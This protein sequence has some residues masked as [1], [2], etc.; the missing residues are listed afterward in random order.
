MKHI[1]FFQ[2]KTYNLLSINAIWRSF[3]FI[4]IMSVTQINFAQNCSVN[5]GGNR[6]VCANSVTLTGTRSTNFSGNPTWSLLSFTPSPGGSSSTAGVTIVSPNSL[7]TNVTGLNTSGVYI[8]RLTQACTA[9]GNAISD[10]EIT[11]F[12]NTGFT[13]GPDVSATVCATTGTTNLT[14]AVIPAG[15]TGSWAIENT[16]KR[17]RYNDATNINGQLSSTTIANPTFSLINKTNHTEDPTYTLTLTITSLDG[18]CSYTDSRVV[19]FCPNTNLTIP[20]TTTTSCTDLTGQEFVN[21]S[22]GPIWATSLSF[23]GPVFTSS[24]TLSLNVISQPPGANMQLVRMQ[25]SQGSTAS[26]SLEFSGMTVLGTYTYTITATSCCGTVTSSNRTITLSGKNPA[27]ANFT[28][29]DRPEQLAGWL[30]ASASIKAGEVKCN[31]AN[32]STPECFVFDIDPSDP[33]N[34]PVSISSG[35]IGGYV[36]PSG[37]STPTFTVNRTAGSRRVEVCVNPGASGWKAGSYFVRIDYGNTPCTRAEYYVIHISDQ[38]RTNLTVANQ[39]VCFPG[40]G[41]V[42]ATV[43]LPTRFVAPTSNPSYF[44]LFGSSLSYAFTTLS[45]PSGSATPV[46]TAVEDRQLVDASTTIGNLNTP[47]EYRFRM[48]IF[49]GNGSG[50]F[51]NQ[52]FACSNASTTAEFSIFVETAQGSNAGSSQSFACSNLSALVGNSPTGTNTGLWQLVSK[53]AGATDPVISNPTSSSTNLSGINAIGNYTFS[54]TITSQSGNCSNSSNVTINVQ[55]LA[56]VISSITPT[57]IINGN[58]GTITVSA[59]GGNGT[60]TYTITRGSFSASNTSGVFNNL[61]PGVYNIQVSDGTC[62][63]NILQTEVDVDE[64]NASLSGNIDSDSDGV[65]D[66]CDLDSDNDGILN[67]TEGFVPAG[68]PICTTGNTPVTGITQSALASNS[69]PI[70][71]I[72]DG[73]LGFPSQVRLS[74]I[75]HFMVIDLG[76][77]HQVG[78]VIRFH[79]NGNAS[80]GSVRV[81]RTA[82]VPAGS[83][84]AAG[85]SNVFLVSIPAAGV[86]NTY[87]YT[88]AGATR[89]IQLSLDQYTGGNVNIFEA[90]I[91]NACLF[92]GN[93]DSDR[94]GIEDHLDSDSDNDGVPDALEANSSLTPAQLDVNGRLT[95]AVNTT[96]GIKTLAGS[97]FTP[98]DTDGEGIPNYRDIDGDNDGIVDIIESQPTV[99]YKATTGIVNSFGIDNAFST[100]GNGVLT[101]TLTNTDGA[102]D[103]DMFDA[104]SDN[105]GILDI[106]EAAQGTY[107]AVDT[108]GDGLANVFDDVV[109]STSPNTNTTNGGQTASNPFPRTESPAGQPNWRNRTCTQL[110]NTGTPS[111]SAAVGISTHTAKQANWPTNVPNGIIVLES[112]NK[113]FVITRISTAARDASSFVPVEGMLIYNTTV[114]RFQLRKAGAWVNLKRG[115]IN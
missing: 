75:N 91:T 57:A 21:I 48:T 16:F 76:V 107:A 106:V 5:A 10:V 22:S 24:G 44:Q 108:D 18:S 74:N 112:S 101:T 98:I 85:G 34:L 50:N 95:G 43:N 81:I 46:F 47:G 93:R 52:D 13:A 11:I 96:T 86:T 19:A 54:W 104:D 90:T 40:T 113:G 71:N 38:G 4:S 56:P 35:G 31:L 84:I 88:L 59:S 51:I 6:T 37:A 58:D 29:A 28:P 111:S 2:T 23:G 70:T 114:N 36:L 80:T 7:T 26:A 14:G 78:S 66:I 53:P 73:V 32:T 1:F 115:C 92:Q 72:N 79:Y 105:D 67:S 20:A 9:G 61:A 30:G 55:S 3:L 8:F 100:V 62:P 33:A 12:A 39:T 49:N 42:T 94:D 110:P 41:S 83:Y 64:C 87:D 25:T 109:L 99:G 60:L 27:A 17:V 103:P 65:S 89:Y 102:D 68:S 97:G 77:V 69:G 63:S 45:Q 82:E 15:F